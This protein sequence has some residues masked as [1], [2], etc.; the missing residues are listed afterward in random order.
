L[1]GTAYRF[2]SEDTRNSPTLTLA[3]LLLQN[4]CDVVLHDPYVKQEDQKLAKFNL[5]KYFTNDI[6]KALNNAEVAIFCTAHRVY[7]QDRE[8][9]LKS[10]PGLQGV[11]DG[12][13]LFK[14]SDFNGNVGYAGIGRSDGSP[15]DTFIDFV[16]NGFRIMECGVANEVNR[17]VNFANE[18]FATDDFNRVDFKEMQRIAG[19]CITGCDIV[20]S[21]PIDDLPEYNGFVPRLVQ[22]AKKAWENG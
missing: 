1:L 18:R 2:N 22:C 19:T 3:E 17:F 15:G 7:S 20:D 21:A 14:R 10:A 11:F 12:C 8:A 4:R 5:Q 6:E 9:L 13:N 16:H